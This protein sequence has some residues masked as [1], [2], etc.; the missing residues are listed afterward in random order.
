MAALDVLALVSIKA[1]VLL[2]AAAGGTALLRRWPARIRVVVLGTALAGC[3]LIPLAAP[4]LPPLELPII[5]RRADI[6]TRVTR[7]DAPDIA[8]ARS[9]MTAVD[10]PRSAPAGE[11]LATSRPGRGNVTQWILPAW[12]GIACLV[13]A[14]LAAGLVRTSRAI[15]RA[16]PI[17]HDE[18]I[19]DVAWACRRI[20]I[21]RP[22]RVLASAAVD[23]PATAGVIRP[24]VLIPRSAAAWPR[25]R[26]RAVLLHELV[27]VDRYDWPL[28][29]MARVVRG[30]YWFNPL[31]WWATHRLDLD[32][33]LACDEEVVAL[34]VRPSAYAQHLLGIARSMNRHSTPALAQLAMARPSNLEERIMT[35][36]GRS[37]SRRVSVRVLAPA[38]VLVAAL[39]PALAAVA[40]TDIATAPA[41]PTAPPA[42]TTARSLAPAAPTTPPAAT[43]AAP[44]APQEIPA[45]LARMKA[46]EQQLEPQ[47]ARIQVLEQEMTPELEKISK[48]ELH[49]DAGQ[50]AD[51][52]AAM[53]PH[54]ARIEAIE[55]DMAPIE[56][57]MEK[58]GKRLESLELHIDA[59]QLADIERQIREQIEPL[60][61]ELDRLHES[62]AP[63]LAQIDT[64]HADLEPLHRRLEDLHEN[65]RPSQEELEQIHTALEPLHDRMDQIHT[66]MEPIHEEMAALGRQLE[67]AVS[68]EVAG[69]LRQHLGASTGPQAPLDEAAARLLEDAH[70]DVR[71]DVVRVRTSAAEA[72][73]ILTDLLGP[74]RIGSQSAFDDAVAAAADAVANLEIPAR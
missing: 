71:D 7:P 65:L 52:E 53:Q 54:I 30:L 18:W 47:L 27:H 43:A 19:E 64:I 67:A 31:V 41:A 60:H 44:A 4:L 8:P 24:A 33:E 39:V 69:V 38:A 28:R 36:L 22:V 49:I 45:I 72:R 12:A 51:I 21:A 29:V 25:E 2:A 14:P 63:Y 50:L 42:A 58:I 5:P 74:H 62:M 59:G 17:A 37:T 13:L 32:Q 73:Q 23:V 66:T 16:V 34:G 35:I 6:E 70:I 9:Q 57:E 15:R 10:S 26:R 20:G 46:L 48:L 40:P 56:A 55:L 1:L 3:L 68:T 61:G 11:A